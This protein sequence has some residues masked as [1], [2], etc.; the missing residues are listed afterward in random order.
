MTNR[1][2]LLRLNRI[3]P[4]NRDDLVKTLTKQEELFLDRMTAHLATALYVPIA[5]LVVLGITTAWYVS[6]PAAWLASIYFAR[7]GMEFA[8]GLLN[9]LTR[10]GYKKC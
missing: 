1:E 3:M 10:R 7:K 5:L 8:R 6:I 2:V 4:N 9:L